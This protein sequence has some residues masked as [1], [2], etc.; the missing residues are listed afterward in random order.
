[1]AIVAI[2][3]AIIQGVFQKDVSLELNIAFQDHKAAFFFFF[4]FSLSLA[5]K[6]RR[7][8]VGAW[9]RGGFR[10]GLELVEGLCHQRVYSFSFILLLRIGKYVVNSNSWFFVSWHIVRVGQ[11]GE[12]NI[13]KR[14]KGLTCTHILC[15]WSMD[16]KT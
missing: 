8:K 7:C 6:L 13:E 12:E 15:F 14:G 3:L 9:Q 4:I 1:M 16:Y 11:K 5:R 10:K 2:G